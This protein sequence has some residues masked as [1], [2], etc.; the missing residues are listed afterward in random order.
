MLQHVNTVLVGKAQTATNVASTLA[1][2]T[3][4]QIIMINGEN[5]KYIANATDAAAAKYIKLG[6]VKD[7]ANNDIQYSNI[8]GRDEIKHVEVIKDN[9]ASNA[10]EA[11]W[12]VTFNSIVAG[13]RYVLRIVYKDMFELPG[14]FTHTYEY[15]AKSGDTTT[16]LAAN[17][18][19]LIDKHS[20]ARCTALASA[21]VLTLTA[22]VKDDNE[23]KNSINEYSQVYMQPF[24]YMNDY[25]KTGFAM[26][27]KTDANVTIANTTL[28]KP[29]TGNPKIVRDREKQAL[30]YRGITNRTWF[31]VIMP[32]LNVDLSK[33]YASI[34]IESER[35]YQSPDNQYI[36]TTPVAT[37]IYVEKD[38]LDNSGIKKLIDAFISGEAA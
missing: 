20:G 19:A 36:K 37:E 21:A 2:N 28:A 33:V 12:T 25:S 10:Q 29:G 38:S 34:V 18:K 1:S 14:Q 35:K 32:D 3:A 27:M 11:V 15:I 8:I 13:N 4:G 30:G 9:D 7:A 26:G 6:L 5:G 22:K 23:G 17:F 24:V 16:N 31:P